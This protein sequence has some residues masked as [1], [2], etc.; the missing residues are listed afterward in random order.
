MKYYVRLLCSDNSL[1]VKVLSINILLLISL[2]TAAQNTL[3]PPLDIDQITELLENGIEESAVSQEIE[4]VWEHYQKLARNP[5]N[6]NSASRGELLKLRVLTDF[7]IFALLDHIAS[8][9]PVLSTAELELVYGFNPQLVAFLSPFILFEEAAP[10]RKGFFKDAQSTLYTKYYVATSKAENSPQS[11][12]KFSNDYWLLKYNMQ[13]LNWLEVEFIMEKDAGEPYIGKNRIPAGDYISGSIALYNRHIGNLKVESLILGDMKVS[14]GQ[15]LT[16]CNTTSFTGAATI[17]GFMKNRES[18]GLYTS[19]DEL[20]SLRGIGATLSYG[21]VSVTP[22][23]SYRGVDATLN[24]NGSYKSLKTDGKHTSESLIASQNSMNE[25]VG[26]INATVHFNKFK[27]GLSYCGY[28]YTRECGTEAKY[29]NQNR[30]YNGFHWNAGVDFLTVV[31]GVRLY[32]EVAY[33]PQSSIA[34]LIGA[35]I[36]IGSSNIYLL[37]R[38]YPPEYIAPHAGAYSTL[39][40]VANQEGIT[41][42][43]DGKIWRKFYY[44][45]NASLS[46]YPYYRYNIKASSSNVKFSAKMGWSDKDFFS[47]ARNELFCTFTYRNTIKYFAKGEEIAALWSLRWSGKMTVFKW[48]NISCRGE[49]N[50]EGCLGASA[51]LNI[52]TNNQKLRV[53]F[54]GIWYNAPVWDGRIYMYEQDL[55]QTFSSTM[56][57]GKGFNLSGIISYRPSRHI[58]VHLK[59][60]HRSTIKTTSSSATASASTSTATTSAASLQRPHRTRTT[61]Q[62]LALRIGLLLT[63]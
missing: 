46:Y 16:L 39:S 8:T 33:S 25:F 57:Y 62:T 43:A 19:T 47:A 17:N 36:T 35:N 18:I 28:T 13:Y 20:N 7:Q 63:F 32:G 52:S 21:R 14:F 42:A 49:Y 23:I 4:E 3:V 31:N 61:A 2:C 12:Y 11:K 24:A 38:Y 15:G 30:L 37:A 6:I 34:A 29:Y 26:G 59:L 5:L 44:G 22:V 60:S 50:I 45:A 9:G 53:H 56:L 54:G 55:P 58:S 41:I 51:F 27:A 48:A 10:L 40:Y 1:V